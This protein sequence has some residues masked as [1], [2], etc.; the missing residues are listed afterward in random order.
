MIMAEAGAGDES[1]AGELI[2][3]KST[4]A[5]LPYVFWASMGWPVKWE[6]RVCKETTI[7]P[8]LT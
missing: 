6:N 7:L 1:E 8:R 4:V 2:P 5:K 3:L